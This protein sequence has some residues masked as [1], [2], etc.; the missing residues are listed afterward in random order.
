MMHGLTN[1]KLIKV[2]VTLECKYLCIQGNKWY[3]TSG[4]A[5]GRLSPMEVRVRFHCFP[6]GIRG[7]QC[8]TGTGFPPSAFVFLSHSLSP[9]ELYPF[10]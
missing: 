10:M 3:G 6:C 5:V 7:G 9:G 8:G 1:L 2:L 4:L